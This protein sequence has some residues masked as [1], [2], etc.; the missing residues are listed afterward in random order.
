MANIR[1]RFGAVL[2]C[3]MVAACMLATTSQAQTV[4]GSIT[5]TVTDT[6]GAAIPKAT[7]IATNL[8]TGVKS[9]TTTNTQGVYALQFL[10]IG[11]YS[12]VINSQGFAP[13]NFDKFALEIDQTVKLNASLGA[14]AQTS[15]DVTSDTAAILNTTDAT[16]GSVFTAN[17]IENLPLNGLD[18]SA[19]T[20]YLPGSVDTAGTSGTTSFERSISYTDTPNM[21]GNRAQANNYTL[22]GIDINETFNNLIGYSP[23]PES[24]GEVKVLTANSP[25]DYGNVN[26]GGVVSVL[27]SGTNLYHGSFYGYEQNQKFNANSWQH[28]FNGSPKG[29]FSQA[30]FGASFGGPVRIP[31]LFNG[32]DKLFF[33]VDYLGSRYHTGGAASPLTILTPAMLKGDF[34]AL[35]NLSQPIQLYD[36]ENNYA[37]YLN[38][39]VPVTNPVAQFLVANP[40]L[41]PAPNR[42]PTDGVA[43]NNYVGT[44]RN[45]HAN[46]QGDIKI[47][48]NLRAADRISSFWA[49]STG[50]DA[51]TSPLAITF[52]GG[53]LFPTKIFGTTWTHTFSSALINSARV[54]FTRIVW[55]QGLPFDGTGQFG[56][57][58]NAKVGIPFPGQ[59][60]PGFSNQGISQFSNIG[61]P[62]FDGGLTDNTYSYI[63]NVTWQRGKH[64]LSMGVQAIR[65]QNNYPTSNNNGFLGTFNYSGKFVSNP[66][67]DVTDG[68]GYGGADFVLD[69]VSTEQVTLGSINVGQRQWRDA[70]FFQDD[71][72]VTPNLTLNAGLRYE[73][74]EPWVEVNNKT[75]NIDLATGQYIYAGSVP[76]GAPA[77]SGVCSN[78]GC[79]KPNYRQLAPRLGFA[80]QINPRLV[81]RGGYGATSFYEGNSSNQRLTAITPFISAINTVPNLPTPTSGGAFLKVENGFPAASSATTSGSLS[82]YP[83]NIQPAYV[84]EWSLTTEYAL[85]KTLSLQVGYLGEKGDHIE[86]YGNVNQQTNPSDP[87]SAPYYNNTFLNI[88]N[89]GLLI[90]E[91]R[92]MMNFNA[93]ESV[94]RERLKNG[95]EFT[96][97]Y[98]FAK[99]MTNSLGNYG[100]NVS[101]FS[102]AFQNYYD[103]GAD[104]GP[105]GYDVRHN[106][107][108]TGVYALPFGHGRTYLSQSN[109][110]VDAAIGGWKVSTAIVGYSGFPETITGPG[111]N[112]GSYGQP[113][114]NQYRKLKIVHQSPVNW[115]GTDPSATPCLTPGVDNG[116]CAFGPADSSHFGTSRNGSVRGPGY[117]NADLSAFKDFRTYKEQTLTFRYDLFNAF[118]IVSY[119]NPDVNVLD[120]T[121]GQIVS[122]EAIRSTERHMQFSASY[123]F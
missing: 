41:Y 122:Q 43:Q 60:Y 81:F 45:Y 115:F 10:Q 101:G 53:N 80:Y 55:N 73:Y 119:G 112:A 88:G 64:L 9:T 21:N 34:S 49:I 85:T 108:A 35:Y 97:N 28:N 42:K 62:A 11:E 57:N 47:D 98:T 3:M 20:L 107:S 89:G 63:D 14:G 123:H 113:R 69:R 96:V 71:F 23:A 44:F 106:V 66:N 4:T 16:L 61:T 83:Q 5:G 32:K 100:L 93:L 121:F 114:A 51:Q 27:K 95:L 72:K 18:F 94:L 90:T 76:A 92:A 25:A 103:S 56:T 54:G 111:N 19:L 52:P 2:C 22:D 105:A 74:D 84:Q 58:G 8:G 99:A 120:S 82:T 77:G 7:V 91:S 68:Q 39:Q 102:G 46:N 24:L 38:N 78:R 37:P 118:N 26:G 15:V 104:Y 40:S 36:P 70:G 86:D 12:V 75:G 13:K 6:S 117:F 116:V 109:R 79:Y 87:T 65:Y 29:T 33:F 48:Y 50:Y 59:K 67:T 1:S 30:Q 110:L 31:K 17:T